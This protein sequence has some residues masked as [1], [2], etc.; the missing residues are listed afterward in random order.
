MKNYCSMFVECAT[1]T[2]VQ[3]VDYGF[4]YRVTSDDY[5]NITFSVSTCC[6]SPPAKSIVFR[7]LCYNVSD[8]LLMDTYKFNEMHNGLA[9][10]MKITGLLQN[11]VIHQFSTQCKLTADSLVPRCVD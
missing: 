11:D 5:W 1:L 2:V 8:I 6:I 7:P 3:L 4:I 9:G 10:F